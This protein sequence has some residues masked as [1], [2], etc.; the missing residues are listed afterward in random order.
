M[1]FDISKNCF[2]IV[3]TSRASRTFNTSKPGLQGHS[4]L[5]EPGLQGHS[6]LVEPGL[7]GHSILVDQ[8]F[9]DIQY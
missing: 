1:E 3:K 6:I 4:I 9:K 2:G 7:Q 8:G 5:V